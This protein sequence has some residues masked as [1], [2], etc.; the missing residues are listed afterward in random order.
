MRRESLICTENQV[1]GGLTLG[2]LQK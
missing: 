2:R 1:S